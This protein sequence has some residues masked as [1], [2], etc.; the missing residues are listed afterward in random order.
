MLN[1]VVLPAPL[2]PMSD[3]I[4]RT[5][6]SMETSL[7]ATRP[8]NTLLTRSTPRAVAA[9]CGGPVLVAVMPR[10]SPRAEWRSWRGALHELGVLGGDL[11]GH[12][13]LAPPLRDESLGPQQH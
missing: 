6:T 2:G 1:S 8:P 12:L 7:T 5:G 13:Q 11:G 10:S 9:A 3:T 4:E